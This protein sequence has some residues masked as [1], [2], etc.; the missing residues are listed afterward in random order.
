MSNG[1]VYRGEFKNDV[2]YG[3][4]TLYYPNETSLRGIWTNG[5]LDSHL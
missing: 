3:R 1:D 5:V 2:P 4:G